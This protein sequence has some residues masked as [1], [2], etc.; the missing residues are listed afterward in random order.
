VT[1]KTGNYSLEIEQDVS[2]VGGGTMPTVDLVTYV[3]KVKHR[4]YTSE[5]LAKK[6]RELKLPII[7]RMKD[8]QVLV[9]FRTI[10]ED[11]IQ[12]VIE[13]FLAVDKG[14]EK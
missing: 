10:D 2:K 14:E 12:G 5:K 13:G 8:E 11:E 7:V 4:T 9:D 1:S 3:V 6:L